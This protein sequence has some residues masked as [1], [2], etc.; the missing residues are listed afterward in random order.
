MSSTEA[1]DLVD[2]DEDGPA[3][4]P[5]QA[6]TPSPSRKRL[7][8]LGSSPASTGFSARA[9][10][11]KKGKKRSRLELEGGDDSTAGVPGRAKGDKFW[12]MFAGNCVCT[13]PDSSGVLL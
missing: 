6:P 13:W 12:R 11:G 10:A 8:R 7:L 5:T 1:S 9:A 4:A 2:S 3:T